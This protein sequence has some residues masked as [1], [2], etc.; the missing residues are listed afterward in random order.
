MTGLTGNRIK[1]PN[2]VL[3]FCVIIFLGGLGFAIALS[4]RA[5]LLMAVEYQELPI[6]KKMWEIKKKNELKQL[7]IQ[8]HGLKR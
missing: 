7:Q 2:F 6:S 5:S 8:S 3:R 4:W 1:E